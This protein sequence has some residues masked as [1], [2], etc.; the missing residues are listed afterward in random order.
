MGGLNIVKKMA[1]LAI[2]PVLA[3]AMVLLLPVANTGTSEPVAAKSISYPDRLMQQQLKEA[4]AKAGVPHMIKVQQDG[5]E[6]VQWKPEHAQEVESIERQVAG[7]ALPKGRSASFADPAYQERFKDW[8]TKKGFAYELVPARGSEY[9]VW[10]EGAGDLVQQFSK[11]L[12]VPCP[13]RKRS[14]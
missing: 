9:V 12:A 1:L 10:Q 5:K 8:L 2:V 6:Y 13:R 7:A 4:L 14:C 11:E 3:G